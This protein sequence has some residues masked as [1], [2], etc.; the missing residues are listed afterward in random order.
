MERLS[1]VPLKQK[2]L[3][4]VGNVEKR[5]RLTGPIEERLKKLL[6][7]KLETEESCNR[8]RHRFRVAKYRYQV[9]VLAL[10]GEKSVI[11]KYC[12]RVTTRL[13]E[14]Q[15]KNKRLEERMIEVTNDYDRLFAVVGNIRENVH[16]P[17]CKEDKHFDAFP[18]DPSKTL[19]R[20]LSRCNSC[21]AQKLRQ[22]R[23]NRREKK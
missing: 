19:G 13:L 21:Q 22:Y 1:S 10:Q 2:E 20:D 3:F 11:R 23:R 12:D 16:C 5:P 15:A 4:D 6:K 17:K 14:S 7:V 18:R 9:A 8:W